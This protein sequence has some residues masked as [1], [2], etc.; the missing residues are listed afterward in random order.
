MCV[1]NIIVLNLASLTSTVI[2]E[3]AVFSLEQ[4]FLLHSL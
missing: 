2:L 3:Y 1:I 4:K